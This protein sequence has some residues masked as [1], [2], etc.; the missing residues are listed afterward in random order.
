MNAKIKLPVRWPQLLAGTVSMLFT[1]VIYAWSIL[2]MPLA[3]ELGWGTAELAFNYTLTLSVFCAG[4]LL[5]GFLAPRTTPRLRLMICA[6]LVFSGFFL[7]SQLSADGILLLYLSYGILIGIGVGMANN[8]ITSLINLWF[9]DKKGL[10]SGALLM[11]F[12]FSAMILGNAANAMFCLPGLGW[13]GTYR[14][15]AAAVGGI[16]FLAALVLKNP[17]QDLSFPTGMNAQKN[18]AARDY[19]PLEMLRR[20]SFWLLF[21][22]FVLSAS[23]GSVA[24]AFASDLF[25]A[26]GADADF[27]VAMVG[28]LSLFNGGGRLLSGALFDRFGMRAAQ[29]SASAFAISAPLLVLLA[30]QTGSL[31]IAI[32][33][34][35]LCGVTYG[36]CPTLTASFAAAFYGLKH[37]P[38]NFSILTLNLLPGSFA[39]ALAGAI[40]ARTGSFTPVFLLLAGLSLLGLGIT[41]VLRHP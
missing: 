3:R 6:A 26:V 40:A 19:T 25:L 5:S 24:M 15:L 32:A 37:F 27:A 41:C 9:P 29:F 18:A 2:K 35:C 13:R 36:F 38:I 4:G 30:L 20:P 22:S 14:V 39:A 23:I 8:T 12:G 31:P 1:G 28:V 33:G 16:L 7:T 21:L 34:I 17:P 10:A 11:A